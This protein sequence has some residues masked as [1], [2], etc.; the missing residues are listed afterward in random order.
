MD[1]ERKLE[2]LSLETYVCGA[3]LPRDLRA[4]GVIHDCRSSEGRGIDAIVQAMR[5]RRVREIALSTQ[6]RLERSVNDGHLC[7]RNS[8]VVIGRKTL[9][10]TFINTFLLAGLGH[11]ENCK[12]EAS[13]PPI[14]YPTSHGL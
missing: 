12:L 6:R 7:Q 8:A 2:V 3:R 13:D 9:K 4:A 5:N 11:F 1:W 10:P 14:I